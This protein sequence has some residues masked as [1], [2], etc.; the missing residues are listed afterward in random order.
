MGGWIL[1]Q[2][3][4]SKGTSISTG[5]LQGFRWE[6]QGMSLFDPE[7][8]LQ[9]SEKKSPDKLLYDIPLYWVVLIGI[10]TMAEF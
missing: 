2:K 4:W 8:A 6:T 5:K 1:Q 3:F 10:L 7:K 9:L